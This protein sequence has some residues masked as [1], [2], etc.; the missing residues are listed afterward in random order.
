MKKHLI[1]SL[2]GI[3]TAIYATAD[4]VYEPLIV[5]SGFNRDVIAETTSISSSAWSPLY[6]LTSGNAHTSCFGTRSV[7][8]SINAN[9]GF[10]DEDYVKTIACGWPDDNGNP[11]DRVIRC[12]SEYGADAINDPTFADVYWRLALYDEPNVLTLRPGAPDSDE[13][14]WHASGTLTFQKIGCYDQLFFLMASLRQGSGVGQRKVTT[15]VHYTD[16]TTS[17]QEFLFA[18]LG[19]EAGQRVQITNIYESPFKKNTAKDANLAYVSVFPMDVNPNK[20]IQSIEFTNNITNTAAIIFAVTGRT[21]SIAA[22]EE[23]EIKTSNITDNS[24]EACW[25]A[26]A[27]AASYRLDVAT[28]IDFQHILEDYNNKVIAG[29]TTCQEVAE[30][31]AE[32][33]YYWRVRSVNSEGG[34][35]ASSAPRRVKTMLEGNT[36]QSTYEEHTNIEAEISPLL[37]TTT[38]IL[39]HRTLYKDG[40][41]NTICLPFSLDADGIATSPLAGCQLYTFDYAEVIG[42]AQLDVHMNEADAIVAGVP[43]LI[44]WANTGTTISNLVF[45]SVTITTVQGQS[46]GEGVQFVG[47]VGTAALTNG[48]HHL[49]FVGGNNTLY[50]PNTNNGLK[51]FRAH[52][53]VPSTGPVAVRRGLPARIVV[54][55]KVPT[56][57]EEGE[58]NN[59]QSTKEL[60]DG[61]VIIFRGGKSYNMLGQP[62]K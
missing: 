12:S 8:A 19:G 60:R 61:K 38:N 18:G 39:I 62:N 32:N 6:D 49:L 55:P 15:I 22:P 24:F 5:A 47:N 54:S 46:V 20:L 11:D 3:L 37:S 44:K 23:E 10:T 1:F 16:G 51:G 58:P 9:Q 26:I 14:G 40:C 34:Q 50:W 30:L 52:F 7:I 42:D 45:N 2:L 53:A 59:A 33:D 27:D 25:D 21:A 31:V 13:K 35:S 48:D 28:D 29:E 41:F 36:P 17:N 43:Y 57:M 56:D 4:V